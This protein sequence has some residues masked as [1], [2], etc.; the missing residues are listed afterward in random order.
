MCSV[1]FSAES[2]KSPS[3]KR[4][5]SENGDVRN[6]SDGRFAA[7]SAWGKTTPKPGRSPSPGWSSAVSECPCTHA[8]SSRVQ[9]EPSARATAS[10][11]NAP[12]QDGNAPATADE[13]TKRLSLVSNQS[14]AVGWRPAPKR[15]P[16]S[17]SE[18][19]RMTASGCSARRR[20]ASV[21][22]R[23]AAREEPGRSSGPSALRRCEEAS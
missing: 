17:L 8:G 5:S 10:A 23:S 11:A 22:T 13:V 2:A 12:A 3:M 18:K 19:E 15:A 1:A 14:A 7:A 6:A 21:S 20:S 4:T 9:V 16:R